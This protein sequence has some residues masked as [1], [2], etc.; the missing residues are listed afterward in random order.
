MSSV[1]DRTR[2]T[3]KVILSRG[4]L[5]LNHPSIFTM[6]GVVACTCDPATL[7]AKSENEVISITVEGSSPSIGGCIVGLN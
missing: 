3:L 6:P 2:K 4:I 1:T 5:Q 7:K